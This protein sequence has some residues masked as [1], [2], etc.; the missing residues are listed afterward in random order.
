MEER[1]LI[2]SNDEFLISGISSILRANNI[3]YSRKE[4]RTKKDPKT[5]LVK[6]EHYEKAK[7]LIEFVNRAN[8]EEEK[9]E[10]NEGP[11]ELKVVDVDEFGNRKLSLP[12][13][14]FLGILS[15]LFVVFVGF[16]ILQLVRYLHR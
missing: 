6:E 14:I 15:V 8:K 13:K 9:K 12:A 7:K 1:E 3:P 16:W 11:S 5:I 2:S 10:A 4:G